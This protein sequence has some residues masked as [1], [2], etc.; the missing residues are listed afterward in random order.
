MFDRPSCHNCE[1][2]TT[3]RV[4]D[5]TIGDFW[6]IDKVMPEINDDNTGIS[7]LTVNSE[8]AKAIFEEVKEW[9]E[10]KAIDKEKAFTYNHNS[11]LPPHKNRQKFFDNLDSMPIIENMQKCLKVSF[12]RKVLIKCKRILKRIINKI[13]N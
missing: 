8:K 11:N 3:N 2:S 9:I 10:F 4:T 7:L 6:G 13:N 12:I 1:F 5:F